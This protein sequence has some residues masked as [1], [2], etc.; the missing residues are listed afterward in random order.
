MKWLALVDPLGVSAIP[1]DAA[2]REPCQVRNDRTPDAQ[3]QKKEERTPIPAI[4]A[5]QRG[6][7]STGMFDCRE[8]VLLVVD[9]PRR[10]RIREGRATR[11][12]GQ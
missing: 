2:A 9:L 11:D 8:F 7:Q 10:R 1:D 4:E 5:I 6:W 12:T 3:H